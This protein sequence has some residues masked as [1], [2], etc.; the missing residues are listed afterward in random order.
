MRRQA[1]V[2][3]FA[4][5]GISLVMVA[6]WSAPASAYQ[7]QGYD[8]P[9][10]GNILY[11]PGAEADYNG[12]LFPNYGSNYPRS[13]QLQYQ[14]GTRAQY[15]G[16]LLAT[17][18]KAV[19]DETESVTLPIRRSVDDGRT[20]TS[21]ATSP[22][23]VSSKQGKQGQ[24]AYG[25]GNPFLY[26][27]PE[28]VGDMP[29]GTLLLATIAA[30]M[31]VSGDPDRGSNTML[32]LSLFR[33][34]DAGF[35]WRE[36]GDIAKGAGAGNPLWEPYL[37][38][39]AGKLYCFYSDERPWKD[40]KLALDASG[41]PTVAE[42]GSQVLTHQTTTDG[43]TWSQP[44]LD[45]DG[46]VAVQNGTNPRPGMA[47]VRQLPN[48]K[49]MLTYEVPGLGHE[50]Y[51][52]SDTP[53]SWPSPTSMG[54]TISGSSAGSPYWIVLPDGRTVYNTANHVGT[55]VNP[56]TTGN[57]F[58]SKPAWNYLN[59]VMPNGYSRTLQYNYRTGRVNIF[60]GLGSWDYAATSHLKQTT[61]NNNPSDG[62]LPISYGEVN[63][64]NSRGSYY[65]ITNALTG[66]A[67]TLPTPAPAQ[68]IDEGAFSSTSNIAATATSA[69]GSATQQWKLL[70]TDGF[71]DVTQPADGQKVTLQ[72][73]TTGRALGL[74]FTKQSSGSYT[75]NDDG[76]AVSAVLE[77]THYGA[78]G[79]N[80]SLYSG[81]Q[82]TLKQAVGGF[83]VVNVLNGKALAAAADGKVTVV[84]GNSSDR[85][86]VWSFA[87]SAPFVM[88]VDLPAGVT[89][90]QG[91]QPSLPANLTERLSDGTTKSV[92][93]TWDTAH[94]STEPTGQRYYGTVAGW[95][96]PIS[97][98]VTSTG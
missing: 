24:Y 44:T 40:G 43:S 26:E 11:D 9:D 30:D 34:D 12:T 85:S 16:T 45:V 28:Q 74:K 38:A 33:S 39:Y 62:P 65:K 22:F 90:P 53:D 51:K 29:P 48:K 37:I 81:Q 63:L 70:N 82:W 6:A 61:P 69:T 7:G 79:K 80:S 88:S 73:R 92:A 93:V 13:V 19:K 66:T 58:L 76:T 71:A 97:I 84:A 15:N 67:L 78:D 64:G 72:V 96:G 49:W 86:Q 91:Q 4:A 10:I 59:S 5:A 31:N 89:A 41:N 35:T 8:G 25:L 77:V 42:D 46:T 57:N 14:T 50:S 32:Y 68:G 18:R 1:A 27:L 3:S 60:R 94:P 95:S 87:A 52:I 56:D 54:S 2:G 17:Y 20:W 75:L 36:V 83:Q 98:D 47:V 21:P 55:Y 23:A